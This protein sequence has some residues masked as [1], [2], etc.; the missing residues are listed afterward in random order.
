LGVTLFLFFVFCFFL[1][2]FY[3]F[4]F[5]FLFFFG[6]LHALSNWARVA[7]LS[8]EVSKHNATRRRFAMSDDASR[9]SRSLPSADLLALRDDELCT[10]RVKCEDAVERPLRRDYIDEL[11][12][13]RSDPLTCEPNWLQ[14]SQSGTHFLARN[15]FPLQVL[16]APQTR[17][18]TQSQP[19]QPPARERFHLLIDQSGSMQGVNTSLCASARELVEDLAPDVLVAVSTFSSDVRIGAYSSRDAACAAL[20]Q[21]RAA[22]STRMN[23]AILEVIRA[24][25]DQDRRDESAC[26]RNT[27]LVLTDG[28]DNAST[29]TAAD[30]RRALDAWQAKPGHTLIFLG[31]YENAEV[32]ASR[33]GVP[34]ARAMSVAPDSAALRSAFRSVSENYRANASGFSPQQRSSS[35][36]GSTTR[37]S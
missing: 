17:T 29:S 30:V 19:A 15:G 13:F 32:S 12:R 34:A 25:A 33:Y 31:A 35:S 28:V 18:Q 22:G 10:L 23:D 1:W 16:R 14:V 26:L 5:C 36:V 8:A 20:A 4:V 37:S 2:P 11:H 6:S 9:P 24:D 3:F 27:L 21:L 7:T